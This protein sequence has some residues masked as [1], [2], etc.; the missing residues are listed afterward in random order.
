MRY[1][2]E[3]CFGIIRAVKTVH[4]SNEDIS[5]REYLADTTYHNL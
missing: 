2:N 5:K 4:Y 1:P 3:N